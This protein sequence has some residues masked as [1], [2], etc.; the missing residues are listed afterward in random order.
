MRPKSNFKKACG[1]C[2][3]SSTDECLRVRFAA[4]VNLFFHAEALHNFLKGNG[5]VFTIANTFQRTLGKIY[6]LESCNVLQDCLA[7]VVTLA[8][9]GSAS[10]SLKTFFDRL[11]KSDGQHVFL[12]IQV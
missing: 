7:D 12:A 6:V 10:Q 4:S 5:S 1:G 11:W 3:S 9:P 2:G 8:A